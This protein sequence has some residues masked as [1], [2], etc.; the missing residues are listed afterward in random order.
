M[1][2]LQES[3]KKWEDIVAGTGH[4]K[5]VHNCSLCVAHHE[6]GCVGCPIMGKTGETGCSD[7]PWDN[8]GGHQS[9]HHKRKDEP[10]ISNGRI[11]DY[12]CE[13]GC[14]ECVDLATDELN[15][16]RSLE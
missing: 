9:N 11:F 3:I 13:P 7:T 16:L 4:D 5:G 14:Q 12:F 10:R 6:N 2:A 15:F 1:S 8:W